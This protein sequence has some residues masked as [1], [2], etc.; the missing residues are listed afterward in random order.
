MASEELSDVCRETARYLA[1]AGRLLPAELFF[2]EAEEFEHQMNH[3]LAG[4]APT[5]ALDA[6][7]MLGTICNGSSEVWRALHLAAARLGLTDGARRY[8]QLG[9]V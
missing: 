7:E 6:A 5:S 1:A 4:N 9:R 2:A 8:A 3:F